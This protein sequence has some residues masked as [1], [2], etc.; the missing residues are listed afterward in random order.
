M[1]GR[2]GRRSLHHSGEGRKGREI[3]IKNPADFVRVVHEF[4]LGLSRDRARP[5]TYYVN[6]TPRAKSVAPTQR[7]VC[8]VCGCASAEH[9]LIEPT[10]SDT[11]WECSYCRYRCID[12][13]GPEFEVPWP[14]IQEA[15]M[16]GDTERLAEELRKYEEQIGPGL[17]SPGVVPALYIVHGSRPVASPDVGYG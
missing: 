17:I 15:A 9:H 14:A 16:G 8:V 4:G 6:W 12:T 7:E 10:R 2:T 1:R 3:G 13:D 11:A 5:H